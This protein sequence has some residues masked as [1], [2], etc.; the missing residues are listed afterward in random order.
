MDLSIANIITISVSQ[1]PQGAGKY[2]TS[3]IGLFSREAFNSMTFG[4]LGYKIYLEPS[5]VA[6]DFGTNSVTYAMANS[7][8]SQQPNILAG[9]G[10][11]AVVPFADTGNVTAVQHVTFSS[12]PA[13]GAYKLKYGLLTTGSLNFNDAAATVQSAL[14]ALTGLSSVT[15]TG[16]YSI[17]FTVTF[18]GVSGPATLLVGTADSLQDSVPVNVTISVVTTVPGTVASTE[19]LAVAIARTENLVQYFGII[20]A[21][22]TNQSNTLAAA[23]VVQ[24]LNKMAI[25][26]SRTEADIQ[27]GGTLD[28]LRTGSF[29]QSRGF[30]YGGA[31]DMVCLVAAAAYAGR[32]FSTNFSG[33]NTTQTMQLKTLIGV[34]P[35]PSM[36]QTIYNEA[37]TAGVDIFASIQ[38]VFCVISNGANFYFDQV[39]NLRWFVGDLQINGFNYLRQSPTKVPQTEAGMTGLKGA[40]AVSCKQAISNAYGAPGQWNSATTFGN[41]QDFLNNIQQVGYYIYSTP[42]ALQSQTDRA[43]REAPLIQI[44]LKEAGAIHT[45]TVIVNIN[46]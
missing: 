19:T 7:I 3:N 4:S 8:F 35:D 43:A 36:T 14:Q 46:A 39:Y 31:S 21:E 45:S 34:Q 32:G 29:S 20:A 26:M 5:E 27:A 41:Q 28:L 23:A 11:L 12:V 18:T 37:Q 15:V 10:Y 22:I 25:F 30:Y 1:T 13:S 42:V 44:A 24:P 16:N 6:T 9:N 33:S 38:G 2:N 40:Y 17:G